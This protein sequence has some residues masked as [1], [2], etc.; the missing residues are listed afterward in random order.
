MSRLIA[1]PPQV[2]HDITTKLWLLARLVHLWLASEF[3]P[4]HVAG[5]ERFARYLFWIGVGYV[6]TYGAMGLTNVLLSLHYD[7]TLVQGAAALVTAA[8]AGIKRTKSY[9][10][11]VDTTTLATLPAPPGSTASTVT[12]ITSTPVASDA[13]QSTPPAT[14]TP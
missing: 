12:V 6:V 9:Q 14:P 11:Y 1:L 13:A 7:P 3:A 10:M 5:V 2:V 4:A 8:S